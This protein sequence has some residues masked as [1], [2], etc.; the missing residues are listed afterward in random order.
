M[1]VIGTAGHVDHGKSALVMALTGINPDRLREEQERQMTID[2]GFAW[3]TLPDGESVGII[4]VPGHRDFIENMLAGVGSIDAALFVVAADEG[5]MPQTREHLA[6]LDLLQ[7]ERGVVALTKVDLIQDTEWLE[8]V[9]EDVRSLLAETALSNAPI[10]PVSAH[11]G[12][13]IEQL[14]EV[15]ASVLSEAPVRRDIGQPRLSIDRAFSIS[16]FGTVVTGTL[17]DGSLAVGDQIEIMPRGY[18][19]RI[20]GL[21]THKEKIERAVPGSRVA[22]NIT[23]VEVDDIHR[24]DVVVLPETVRATRRIDVQFDLLDSTEQSMKHNQ[25]VKLFVG[26][27]QRIARVRLLGA[28]ELVP[29]EEGWLQ[30]ELDGPIIAARGDRYIL[31]RPSP[32]ATIGGGQVVDA[33]PGRRHRRKDEVVIERLE[34]YLVGDPIDVLVQTLQRQGPSDWEM[35]AESAGVDRA[36][37]EEAR[38]QAVTDQRVLRMNASPGPLYVDRATWRGLVDRITGELKKYHQQ[39]PLRAGMNVEELR[40]RLKLNQKV[41]SAVLNHADSEDLIEIEGQVARV[42]SFQPQLSD[43]QAELAG[44]MIKRFLREPFTTPS[45]KECEE[46][47]GEEIYHYLVSTGQLIP[48]SDDVVFHKEGYE[49]MVQEVKE[50]IQ[51]KGAVTI[52]EVRDHLDTSRKYVLGLLEHLDAQGVTVR[53]GDLRRL[54]PDKR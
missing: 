51:Q 33:H 44:Q 50:L 20:R 18:A 23:G 14:V 3:L 53:D 32:P 29:G 52:A 21:Q 34:H 36:E 1:R 4:D 31:R 41:A 17:V 49:R 48:V 26:A 45:I 19:G 35:I 27:A 43:M 13:G 22:V 2:L 42:E 54:I 10:V 16:G 12:R 46:A 5:V 39:K 7:I 15:I 28:D 30:L 38:D 6:I 8:L 9:R 24:G 40:S 37:L 11:S 47:V 25:E